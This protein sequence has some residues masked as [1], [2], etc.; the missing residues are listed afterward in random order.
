MIRRLV[1]LFIFVF[2]LLIL[3]AVPAGAAAE[4]YTER[5]F[6]SGYGQ[7]IV[8]DPAA[9]KIAASI[10]VKGP[11]RDMSFTDDGKTGL[12]LAND[13]KSLYVVD[14]VQNKIVNEVNLEARTDQGLLDRRVWGSAISPDGKKAYAFVTQGEKRR[15]SFKVHPSKI[16]EIDLKSKEELRSVEAPY[17]THV[18]QFKQNDANTLFVWG[19][20]LFEL[21]LKKMKLTLR[22]GIKHP[23][24]EKDG[25]GNYLMLFPRGENGMNSIPLMKEYPDGRVTEGIMWM[26]RESGTIKTLEYDREP[27]GMFSAVVDKEENYAYTTLNKWY[28]VDIK[29]QKIVNES[30]PPNGSLYGVNL[31]A[32]EEKVYYSGAGNEFIIANKELE[33]EKQLVLPTDTLDLKVVKIEQ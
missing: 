14:T 33:V 25:I 29:S 32:D 26:N 21:D 30:V 23:K 19:Y 9:P 22:Q 11:V 5:V 4:K 12:F 31:S 16:I 10:K 13:R 8:V 1:Q 2:P 20:D 17:G 28:K 7:I 3:S 24:N 6:I 18:L 15:S 27:V